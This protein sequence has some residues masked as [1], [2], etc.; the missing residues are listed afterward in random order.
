[1]LLVCLRHSTIL[2]GIISKAKVPAVFIP[3]PGGMLCRELHEHASNLDP[4]SGQIAEQGRPR[5]AFRDSTGIPKRR[6][7]P[8]DCL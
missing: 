5:L 3:E 1:M 7:T 2:S 6:K 4:S 8:F